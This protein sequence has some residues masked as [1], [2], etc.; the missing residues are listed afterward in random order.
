MMRHLA[1]LAQLVTQRPFSAALAVLLLS[2]PALAYDGFDRP[3]DDATARSR[4]TQYAL[5]R[6]QSD[7]D[8][9]KH[10]LDD[11]AAA[12]DK[13]QRELANLRDQLDSGEARLR[14]LRQDLDRAQADQAALRDQVRPMR[15]KFEAARARADQLHD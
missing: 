7:F 14:G 15:E 1:H 11:I 13:Q 4:A 8:A 10:R 12:R 9:A 6:D 5:T 2:S 3:Y